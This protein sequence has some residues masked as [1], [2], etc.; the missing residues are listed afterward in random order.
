MTSPAESA[1]DNQ[2]NNQEHNSQIVFYEDPIFKPLHA[3]D[4]HPMADLIAMAEKG[5]MR[6]QF[7]LG[8]LY[9]KGK[10]G[11]IK[12]R[13]TAQHWFNE[14]AIA[15]YGA[16]FLRLAAL[17]KHEGQ[18]IEAYS[19]Y[20]LGSSLASG[21]DARYAAK[22]RDALELTPEDEDKADALSTAWRRAKSQA[23]NAKAETEKAE[24]EKARQ[25]KDKKTGD[26]AA[27]VTAPAK[28]PREKATTA[29]KKKSGTP[30]A[31]PA[32]SATAKQE[33]TYNE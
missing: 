13:K 2:H 10:G 9:A 26:A 21:K 29:D 16:S 33:R 25:A 15:G 6:A 22:A 20:D 18:M 8:D 3:D 17:A 4:E 32:S 23:L 5:D 30:A 27:P 24:A 31:R 12:N 14:S 28:N 1:Q 11:L 7:I 19:W